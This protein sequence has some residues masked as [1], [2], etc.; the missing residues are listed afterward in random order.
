MSRITRRQFVT[1]GGTAATFTSSGAPAQRRAAGGPGRQSYWD[2]GPDKN[3]ARDL[4]PGPT[5]IRLGGSL[6]FGGPRPARGG[7]PGPPLNTAPPPSIGD[8]I[9]TV[10]VLRDQGITA[11]RGSSRSWDNAS[12][13]GIGEL[14]GAL[15]EYDVEVVEV[16]AY[17]N[18]LHTEENA[19][20]E[21]LKAVARA[22]ES[23]ERIGCRMVGVITGSRNAEFNQYGN[24]YAVHADNWT[25]ETWKLTIDGFKQI[26]KDTAGMKVALGLEAQI[27]TNLD[28]ALAHRNMIDDVGDPSRVKVVFDP[29]NMVHLYNYFHTAEMINECFGLFGEEIWGCHA[30]DALVAPHTQTVFV[31]QVTPGRGNVDYETFLVRLSWLKWPRSLTRGC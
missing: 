6:G 25:I 12:E 27:T 4:K 28:T 21:N 3:L 31:Q 29:A 20:Q 10:K 2:P 15:K 11:V 17:R 13:S 14:R 7:Q 22:M 26:L 1:A 8:I 24:N 30:K 16:G 23:A 5:A 19:R 18:L 9:K